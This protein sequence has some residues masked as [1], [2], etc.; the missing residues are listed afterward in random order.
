VT[1]PIGLTS[2]STPIQNKEYQI[3]G[4]GE[5]SSHYYSIHLIFPPIG[6]SIQNPD[7]EYAVIKAISAKGGDAL[8]NV[9]F[10]Q[11]SYYY[12]LISYHKIIVAGDVI[13]FTSVPG[14]K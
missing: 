5:G 3:L 1:I 13:K 11:K 12:L 8:I 2:S 9:R 6:W 4:K 14:K 10:Y 7:I